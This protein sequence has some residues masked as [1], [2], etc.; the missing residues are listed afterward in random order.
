LRAREGNVGY[1]KEC[2]WWSVGIVLYE[3]VQ[4][5]PPFFS[6]TLTETYAKIMNHEVSINMLI[7]MEDLMVI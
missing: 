5:D 4:G 6:D 3:L 2:D 1:G 7:W